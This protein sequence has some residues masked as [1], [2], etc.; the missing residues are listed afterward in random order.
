MLEF[1]QLHS[2]FLMDI[3]RAGNTLNFIHNHTHCDLNIQDYNPLSSRF[4]KRISNIIRTA[5]WSENTVLDLRRSYAKYK[6]KY[7]NL[8]N[9]KIYLNLYTQ[10]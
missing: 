5:S 2:G 3:Q 4:R 6:T 10:Q 1:K 8:P 9:F 7:P